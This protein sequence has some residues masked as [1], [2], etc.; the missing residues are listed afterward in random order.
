MDNSFFTF[1]KQHSTSYTSHLHGISHWQRVESYG[2][3]LAKFSQADTAVTS[4]FAY[5]H[6]AMRENDNKDHEHGS[7]AAEFILENSTMIDLNEQQLETLVFACKH[8]TKGRETDNPTIATCWDADRL[9]MTRI[10]IEPKSKYLF[11]NEAK[12][13]ANEKD[14]KLLRTLF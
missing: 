11:T 1:L 9:D 8:H 5:L 7:R 14:F 4:Y 3:Y 2:R 13:I 10:G 6:D 12:R